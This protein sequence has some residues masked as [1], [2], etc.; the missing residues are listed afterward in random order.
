MT[1]PQMRGV[2][3]EDLTVFGHRMQLLLDAQPVSGFD[4]FE[5]L[6]RDLLS[7]YA[8]HRVGA[9]FEYEGMLHWLRHDVLR[10]WHS[11]LARACWLYPDAPEQFLEVNVK[12]RSTRHIMTAGFLHAL[13]AAETDAG[14]TE[15]SVIQRLTELLWQTPAERLSAFLPETEARRLLTALDCVWLF[16]AGSGKASRQLPANVLSSI[17]WIQESV[18]LR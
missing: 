11:L 1:N 6:Q 15:G 5:E 17:R 10:Y 7:W 16:L 8:E 2:V 3:D 13:N 12:W 9:V 18:P 14:D 4:R